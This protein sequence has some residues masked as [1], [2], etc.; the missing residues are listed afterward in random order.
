MAIS[1]SFAGQ[2]PKEV[3]R[4]LCSNQKYNYINVFVGSGFMQNLDYEVDVTVLFSR[5]STSSTCIRRLI[6]FRT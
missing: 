2:S 5:A 1:Q 4:F 3:I 6:D